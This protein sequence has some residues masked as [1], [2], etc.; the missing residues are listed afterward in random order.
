MDPHSIYQK[1]MQ[2]YEYI[3]KQKE[4][5]VDLSQNLENPNDSVKY[6]ANILFKKSLNNLDQDLT[7]LLVD[8]TME[9][10]DLFCMLIGLTLYGID[11]LSNGQTNVFDLDDTNN[12]FFTIIQSYL[13]SIG[14]Q[15]SIT[16]EPNTDTLYRDRANYHCEIVPKPPPFLCHPGWYVLS[17]RLLDNKKFCFDHLTSL[18]RFSVL[19]VANNK[20]FTIRYN[21]NQ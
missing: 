17:Y 4:N 21:Y 16:N 12:D 7:G 2:Y 13:K 8:D 11:I 10:A 20:L 5:Y 9:V 6:L 15:I 19:F 14:F 18:D 3:E 1:Q